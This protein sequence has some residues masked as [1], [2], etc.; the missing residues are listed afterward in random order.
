MTAVTS[1]PARTTLTSGT[2]HTLS[3]IGVSDRLRPASQT[4]GATD[5]AS[6]TSTAVAAVS[7][8][9]VATD[10][11]VGAGDAVAAR[12]AC[13][14]SATGPAVA[15]GTGQRS[16]LA[17]GP[18]DTTGTT[19][20]AVLAGRSRGVA[21]RPRAAGRAIATGTTMT[22]VAV[23]PAVTTG[24]TGRPPPAFARRERV[25]GI[26][27]AA[28]VASVPTD[29]GRR[30]CTAVCTSHRAATAATAGPARTVIAAAPAGG[31]VTE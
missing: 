3:A 22:A 27:P 29:G 13:A 15:T 1:Q 30:P 23:E 10:Y 31:P 18:A 16:A 5:C 28:S 4:A 19:I 17:A 8:V 21:A 25:R 11:P 7:P 14:A 6:T 12:S 26:G 2:A 20:T 24:P 9:H